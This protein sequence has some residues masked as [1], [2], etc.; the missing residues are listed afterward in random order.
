MKVS[1]VT[2][3][4]N[5]ENSIAATLRS[6]AEQDHQDIEHIVVDGGSTDGTLDV[7]STHGG[8][9][10]RVI[11]E[12]DKGVYDA[13]NKGLRV[14]SGEA[15]VYLNSGDT[16][17]SAAAVS[18]AVRN[19]ASDD[20]Q[21]VFSDVLIV[22]AKTQQRVIRRYSS[23]EFS[24]A[25]MSYGFMPAH[26]SLFLR[27]DVYERVGEYDTQYRI[28]ADFEL[29]LRVFVKCGIKYRYLSEPLVRMPTGGLS[30]QGWRSKWTITREMRRA[31]ALNGVDTSF[32]K[33]CLRFP[34]KV[35]EMFT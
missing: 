20:V 12:R 34:I 13:F 28:S 15:V 19:L 26:P 6:V 3:T 24:P 7:V 16:Y 5:C 18:H 27:R 30:N 35:L 25:R 1:I 17:T 29:C 10:A 31:C 9:V 14:A 2:A 11:S 4:F 33:L 32:A 21:A 23:R 22:D 8:R